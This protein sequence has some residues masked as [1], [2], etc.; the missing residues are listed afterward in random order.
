MLDSPNLAVSHVCHC[1]SGSQQGSQKENFSRLN[2]ILT[3]QTRKET[4]KMSAKIPSAPLNNGYEMPLI[5]F[6]TANV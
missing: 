6:G 5:G 2:L 3:H 1:D 4:K